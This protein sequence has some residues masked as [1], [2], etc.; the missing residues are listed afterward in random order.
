MSCYRK[1]D[2]YGDDSS[3]GGASGIHDDL[4]SA[5]Q[6]LCALLRLHSAVIP[7]EQAVEYVE[8]ESSDDDIPFDPFEHE[9]P[10]WNLGDADGTNLE[11]SLFYT[12]YE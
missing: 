7:G 9:N 10:T 6:I 2:D 1:M 4:V 8:F 12:G 3:F 11:E 5:F